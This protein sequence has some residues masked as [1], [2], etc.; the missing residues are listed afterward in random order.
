MS[1]EQDEPEMVMSDL[2]ADMVDNKKYINYTDPDEWLAFFV[3]MQN[4][5]KQI[6]RRSDLQQKNYKSLLGKFD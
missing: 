5:V 4:L 3:S 6:C 1:R 2:V